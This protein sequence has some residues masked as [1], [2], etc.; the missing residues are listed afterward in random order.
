L[1]ALEFTTTQG[2]FCARLVEKALIETYITII[3]VI[4]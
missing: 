2:L 1:I 4:E 3:I